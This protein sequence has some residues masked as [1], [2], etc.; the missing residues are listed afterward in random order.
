MYCV[1]CGTRFDENTG[2][3]PVCGTKTVTNEMTSVVSRDNSTMRNT[4][5]TRD[6]IRTIYG[7]LE[8]LE[9][10]EEVSK[11]LETTKKALKA[12]ENSLSNK[13]VCIVV[14]TLVGAVMGIEVNLL[15]MLVCGILG[16]ILGTVIHITHKNK[17]KGY[18]ESIDSYS[19]EVE[20]LGQRIDPNG[21]ALLPPSYRFYHAANFFYMAFINQRALTMQEA[22]NLYEDEMRKDQIA[23]MQ[24]QQ[25]AALNSIRTSSKVSAAMSTAN[26]IRGF[27]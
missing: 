12:A 18:Y 26:F 20:E 4:G 23:H 15:G 21:I 19:A 14:T 10:W 24:K 7:L 6:N 3:C 16:T 2:T 5:I 9:K 13:R 22:V 17:I 1:N 27:I 11:K 8:P 25:I